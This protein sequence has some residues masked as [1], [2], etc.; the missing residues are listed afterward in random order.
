MF[1]LK[2]LISMGKGD[3]GESGSARKEALDTTILATAFFEICFYCLIERRGSLHCVACK[4]GIGTFHCFRIRL[5]VISFAQ[6][7]H[8]FFRDIPTAAM[9]HQ[10]L[11]H[12]NIHN[13]SSTNTKGWKSGPILVKSNIHRQQHHQHH[14]HHSS[15]S[16]HWRNEPPR[17]SFIWGRETSV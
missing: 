13:T 12:T 9:Q 4:H 15:A 2:R 14:Q 16:L 6:D 3:D 7:L 11:Q 8:P 1:L 10:Y 5:S 17:W